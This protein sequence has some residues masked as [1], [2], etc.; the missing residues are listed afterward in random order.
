MGH[1]GHFGNT[2]GVVGDG[3]VSVNGDGDTDGGQHTDGSQSHAVQTGQSGSHNHGG[4]DQNDG[5]SGGLQTDREAGQNGGSSTGLGLLSDVLDVLIVTG[6]VDLGDEA[7]GGTA[8]NTG[9]DGTEQAPAAFALQAQD[10]R[11]NQHDGGS[12]VS[13][14]VQDLMRIALLDGLD[15]HNTDQSGNDT[16]GD[17][18]E[19]QADALS[20]AG[21]Q[22][23]TG[24]DGT[25]IGLEQVST[26]TGDVTDVVTD[27]VADNSGVTGVILGD[28]GL[29]LTDQVSTHV[30]SLG[31]DTAADTGKQGDGRSAQRETG[32]NVVVAVEDDVQDSDAQS[33]QTDNAQT[34]NGTAGESD[35]QSGSHAFLS[36]LSSTDVGA[37][38]AD[39][40]GEAGQNR[41]QSTHQEADSSGAVQNDQQQDEHQDGESQHDDVLTLQIGHSA[42]LNVAG[43]FTH[44]GIF[45]LDRSIFA[46]QAE[47]HQQAD[48][49]RSDY[50]ISVHVLF[51]P[52]SF[53][54][55]AK[56]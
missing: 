39:H 47:S 44:T 10:Q 35:V 45:Y 43:D 20:V 49:R 51:S 29:D 50:Q 48:D 30:S 11:S 16:D 22:Q 1:T 8:D 21:S 4:S 46:V 14:D 9:S 33:A 7:D 26:H 24:Q 41:E 55:W 36:L 37:G 27:V 28:A 2:A 32:Q 6:G 40:A 23:Q 18:L 5:Q 38:G 34:Q 13:T 56:S 42:F 19:H 54:V 53:V 52:F 3:A 12:Q 17:H 31:V 25:D 15:N